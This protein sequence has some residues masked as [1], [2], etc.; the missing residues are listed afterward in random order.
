MQSLFDKRVLLVTGKGG[1][2]KTSVAAALAIAAARVGRRVL[3]TEL[4][5]EPGRQ[6]SLAGVFGLRELPAKRRE[7]GEG[8]YGEMVRARTGHEIFLSRI[9]KVRPLI[10]AALASKS[11]SRFLEA[12]P[13]FTEMGVYSHVIDLAVREKKGELENELVVIDM[14]ATGHMIGIAELPELL[15]SLLESGPVVRGLSAVREFVADPDKV[16]ACVVTLPEQLPISEA[17][18]L[19]AELQQRG[20]PIGA[21]LVNRWRRFPFDEEQWAALKSLENAGELA[22]MHRARGARDSEAALQ[23]LSVRTHAP[24]YRF[25]DTALTRAEV[26]RHIADQIPAGDGPSGA[27]QEG[28]S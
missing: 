28:D 26:A 25:D 20:V 5:A 13:S 10:R 3:L 4:D 21:I 16:A 14:P 22:G 8:V 23:R 6:S 1:V 12:A 7:I 11:L 27:L 24:L 19:A 15:I 2:G 9:L 17:G 18:E